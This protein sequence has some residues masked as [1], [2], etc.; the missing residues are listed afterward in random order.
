M[1]R[2][3]LVQPVFPGVFCIQVPSFPVYLLNFGRPILVD[4]GITTGVTALRTA[5]KELLP[6]GRLDSVLLTHSHWDHA[7]GA[8]ELQPEMGF[9]VKASTR[10][11]ELLRKPKVYR[12]IH[13]LNREH[14]RQHNAEAPAEYAPL[15]RLEPLEENDRVDLGGGHWI[16]AF[17]TPGHTRCSMAY[18][19]YPQKILFPGD[20][21]GVVERDGSIKPLFL[22]DYAAYEDSLLKLGKLNARALCFSHNRYLKGETRVR[23]FLAASLERTRQVRDVI[24]RRLDSGMGREEIAEALLA[25]EFPKPTVMGPREA[26]II[27]LRAMTLAV[28][29]T[30]GAC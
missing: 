13:H 15:Q 1:V 30:V 12:F 4:S 28:E 14:A 10:A 19:L 5:L 8:F 6:D 26:L 20:A 23:D 18:L 25:E 11:V 29:R 24:R 22:S 2:S 7:G 3:R 16:E 17:E 9:A 27:N 21:V